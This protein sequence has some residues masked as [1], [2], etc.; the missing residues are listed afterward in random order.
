MLVGLILSVVYVILG[1]ILMPKVHTESMVKNQLGLKL[2]GTV[3]AGKEKKSN[4]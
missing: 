3:P 4:G 1:Y 2:L